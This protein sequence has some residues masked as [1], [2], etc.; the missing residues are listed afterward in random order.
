MTRTKAPMKTTTKI[1]L[2]LALFAV[3]L[4]VYSAA[5]TD[6]LFVDELD[7]FRGGETVVRGGD[8]YDVYIS[9]HMPFSYYFAT[10]IAAFNPDSGFGYR[11]GF[12]VLLSILWVAA[13][14]RHREH[15]GVVTMALM[16]LIFVM[17]MRYYELGSSMVSDHW[18]GIGLALLLLE[19]VRYAETREITAAAAV[20]ISLSIVLS[21]GTAFLSAYPILMVFLGVVLCQGWWSIRAGEK[22]TRRDLTRRLCREDVRL[23]LI[24]LAPFVALFGWYLISGNLQ[25]FYDGAIRLNTEIYPKYI[26]GFGSAPLQS[27][28]SVFRSYI[29]HIQKS[30]AAWQSNPLLS[31]N[32]LMRH[33]AALLVAIW[34][35]RKNAVLG[36]F[37][38]LAVIQTGVRAFDGFHGAPYIAVGAMSIALCL[39]ALARLTVRRRN[40]LPALLCCALAVVPAVKWVQ[41]LPNPII[42]T[43]YALL[44]PYDNEKKTLI[45]S[46][47]DPGEYLHY[48]GITQGLTALAVDR[49]VDFGSASSTPWTYEL[50]ADKE[51]TV[52]KENQTKVILY[53]PGYT[54]WGYARSEYAA[55]LVAYI[56]DN[57]TNLTD[58]VYVRNDYLEEATAR[59]DAKGIAYAVPTANQG[60]VIEG[61]RVT[62]VTV[63]AGESF[64]QFIVADAAYLDSIVLELDP[65]AVGQNGSIAVQVICVD[66]EEET[67][68]GYAPLSLVQED[69][70]LSIYTEGY[71]I[72]GMLFEV[73]FTVESDEAVEIAPYHTLPGTATEDTYAVIGGEEADYSICMRVEYETYD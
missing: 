26:G 18:Q 32:A 42:A 10:L 15:F 65:A 5:I 62:D 59:L 51:M 40:V 58:D 30:F 37:F 19:M 53:E 57:Y 64:S 69:G 70:T 34:L 9:Q 24:C 21:L 46:L 36:V 33:L 45:E 22:E 49:R 2:L 3:I 17:Q 52:L 71:F 31:A 28:L 27:G 41:T 43:G 38:Y 35:I 4:V 13:F 11:F 1:K 8:I 12:Y 14:I 67:A 20:W 7:V 68:S 73:R 63:A 39:G 47:V 23:V 61:E 48:T 29:S 66:E 56:M 50:Y 25:N 54:T 55:P 60:N 72:T 16:P 44:D 6:E